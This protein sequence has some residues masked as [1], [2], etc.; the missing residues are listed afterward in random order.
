MS[1]KLLKNNFL[2]TSRILGVLILIEAEP[3][4]N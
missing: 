3:S 4:G 1:R 2:M